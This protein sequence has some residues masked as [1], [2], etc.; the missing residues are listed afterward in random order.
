LI[1][2]AHRAQALFDLDFTT[3]DMVETDDGPMVFEVSAFG[4]FRGIHDSSGIDA[5]SVL[6]DHVIAKVRHG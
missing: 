5:A 4:G 6:A 1:A 3:V 2:L